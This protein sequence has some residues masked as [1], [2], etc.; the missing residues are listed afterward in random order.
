MLPA[1]LLALLRADRETE[2]DRLLAVGRAISSLMG[3]RMAKYRR[4]K[5][6]QRATR[7]LAWL[8]NLTRGLYW[9]ARALHEVQQGWPDLW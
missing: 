8:P 1:R 4:P 9:L 7:P 5:T 3:A 6:S 2:S